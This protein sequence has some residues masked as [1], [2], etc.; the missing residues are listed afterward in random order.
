L[1]LSALLTD[2]LGGF[3]RENA[4]VYVDLPQTEVA[5]GL[6]RSRAATAAALA[7][8]EEVSETGL[9]SA[10]LLVQAGASTLHSTLV[11]G[12]APSA[13]LLGNVTATLISALVSVSYRVRSAAGLEAAL[14]SASECS[15]LS[16]NLTT[17]VKVQLFQAVALLVNTTATSRVQ[18]SYG[19]TKASAKTV[20]NLKAAGLSSTTGGLGA[21][22]APEAVERVLLL[23]FASYLGQNAVVGQLPV[24]IAVDEFGLSGVLVTREWLDWYGSLN[25]SN[26]NPAAIQQATTTRFHLSRSSLQ[27]ASVLYTESVAL[28]VATYTDSPFP[29]TGSGTVTQE[30]SI[31]TTLQ[32]LRNFQTLDLGSSSIVVSAPLPLTPS[33]APASGSPQSFSWRCGDI[34]PQ[35]VGPFTAEQVRRASFCGH[36]VG[37]GRGGVRAGSNRWM[38]RSS[39]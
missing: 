3:A 13:A 37:I 31:V 6:A 21:A 20:S 28:V 26:V 10:A 25:L 17:D 2:V 39:W 1:G 22:V 9:S 35:T 27:D 14:G 7:S 29:D 23:G 32:L 24:R 5:V 12:T 33:S 36:P 34:S 16:A 15:A 11:S 8:A 30:G 38:R 19:A 4:S 18:L